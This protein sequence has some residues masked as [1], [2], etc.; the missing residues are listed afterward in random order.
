MQ[1]RPSH[2]EDTAAP[3]A[4]G[5]SPS[6]VRAHYDLS[7]EFYA[8]WLGPTMMYT[9]GLWA[10]GDEPRNLTAATDRKIDFF[11][12]HVLSGAGAG[13]LDVGCGWGGN[14]RRLVQRHG[15]CRAIG[16]TLS[17]RQQEWC[18]ARPIPG[19][20]VRLEDWQDH[21]PSE[22]YDAI[23]SYGSFEHVARDGTNGVE[24]VAAY[25]RFFAR[26]FEWLKP[27][28]RIG[29]ETIAHDDARDSD[30]PLGRGP[31]GDVVLEIFPESICP[32]LSEL[33]LGF[34]PFFEVEML[35]ADAADYARTCRLWY[36]SLRECELE[37]SALVGAETLRRFR[38][39]LV[40]SEVQF[41]DG[42]ITNYRLVLR[43][44]PARRW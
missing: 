16:L 9:A 19:V 39:Y 42:T 34:E 17:E 11:A 43:R 28:G 25:R 1:L 35:R 29:L 22:P 14:L 41:R 30:A 21:V 31:L 18:D 33:V 37:A 24:R 38:Q 23:F 40:S 36:R 13:V 2:L 20:E 44:R 26:C 6:A 12:G 8:L 32:H 15:V 4:S 5:A 7:N 10:L 3:V 27:G